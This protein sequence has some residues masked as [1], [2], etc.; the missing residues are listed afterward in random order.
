M[1]KSSEL[2]NV[3]KN[4]VSYK[5]HIA[6]YK[7]YRHLK[8]TCLACVLCLFKVTN[9]FVKSLCVFNNVSHVLLKT[10]SDFTKL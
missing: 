1:Y 2:A 10:H 9:G 3:V 4:N 6:S 5:R 7:E 8:D